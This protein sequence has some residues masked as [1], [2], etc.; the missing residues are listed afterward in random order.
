M[1]LEPGEPIGGR[2]AGSIRRVQTET[3][4]DLPVSDSP[5]SDSIVT[6]DVGSDVPRSSPADRRRVGPFLADRQAFVIESTDTELLA[7]IDDCLCDLRHPDGSAETDPIV[8]LIERN[9]PSWLTHPWALYRDGEPCETTVTGDYIVP[10]VLWEV[11]RLVLESAVA[12]TIPIHAAALARNGK[13][14]VLCGPSHAGKSTLAAWLTHRGWGVLTDEV[15]L[16]D[17]S[18]PTT[19]TVRPF[20]RPVGVRRGGPIDAVVDVPGDEAEVLV[21]ATRLGGLGEP[22]PLVALVCPAYADGADGELTPLSPAE[23]LTNVAEQL[24]SLARDGSTVF[25]ALAEIVTRV[26][27]FALSVDDLD[28]AAATLADL[29]D[30]LDTGGLDTGGLDADGLETGGLDTDGPEQEATA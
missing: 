12:P 22:A 16:L 14:V 13:A 18:E 28:S 20:W 23:A 3:G 2:L 25:H 10:Y 17:I 24:P 30:G 11:T 19:T 27:S 26:P 9:G 8:L 5:R 15:G 29:V 4:H 21:P 7:T 6:A 1:S